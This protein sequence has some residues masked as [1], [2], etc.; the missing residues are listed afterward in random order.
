M[1]G[2]ADH[3]GFF[4]WSHQLICGVKGGVGY[5]NILE[6]SYLVYS[7]L[8]YW[9]ELSQDIKVITFYCHRDNV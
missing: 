4:Q 2:L 7:R 5:I 1:V 9:E 3:V 8:L 6:G